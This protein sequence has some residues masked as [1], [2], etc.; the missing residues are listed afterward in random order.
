MSREEAGISEDLAERILGHVQPGVRGVYARHR[1]TKEMG[2][3]LVRLAA[4]IQDIVAPEPEPAASN[5]TPMRVRR[6]RVAA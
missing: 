5:V 2:A 3:A 6:L 1:F 4:L